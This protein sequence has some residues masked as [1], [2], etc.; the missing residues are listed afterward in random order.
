[1]A[2]LQTNKLEMTGSKMTGLKGEDLPAE[3]LLEVKD[4][5]TYFH[6]DDGVVA[7]G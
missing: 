5:K 7:G 4:L 6:T 3:T 2:E 1:M